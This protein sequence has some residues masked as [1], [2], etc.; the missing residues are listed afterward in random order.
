MKHILEPI[1]DFWGCK[2]TVSHGG[3]C[4]SLLYICF[5]L[6]IYH[7]ICVVDSFPLNSLPIAL[8]FLN[9]AFLE[10]VLSL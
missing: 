4:T 3:T 2:C 10:H 6:R 5:Y 8:L 9:K 1:M 7:L